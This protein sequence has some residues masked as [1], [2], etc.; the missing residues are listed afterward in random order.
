MAKALTRLKNEHDNR[1]LQLACSAMF[2]QFGGLR[3]FVAAFHAYF[4]D[5]K[6][7]AGLGVYRC[8]QSVI[9][10][11][12]YCEE[13]RRQPDEMTDEELELNFSKS[14]EQYIL[15]NPEVAIAAAKR[16]GWQIIP[17]AR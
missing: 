5:A 7:K 9:R 3:G 12:Q 13:N 1:R 8:M 17:A 11:T 16:L 2:E 10:L 4:E 14:I 15:A 6:T